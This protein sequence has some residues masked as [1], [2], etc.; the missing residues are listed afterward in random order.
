MY[1]YYT[2][3]GLNNKTTSQDLEIC[4]K[5]LRKKLAPGLFASNSQDSKQAQTCLKQCEKAFRV[6]SDPELRTRH[7][8][9]LKCSADNPNSTTKPRLGQ[10]CVASGM[11]SMAQL[12]EAVETQLAT[13]APLGEVLEDKHFISR[14]ELEGL[15][16]GQDL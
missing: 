6:L 15:L 9:K 11:I 10:L 14:V 3:L 5:N 4:I 16:L 2:V 12:E 1:S 13:D 8:E 7:D